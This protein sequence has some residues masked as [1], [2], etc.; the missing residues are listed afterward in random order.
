[1]GHVFCFRV[2][3]GLGFRLYSTAQVWIEGRARDMVLCR[4]CVCVLVRT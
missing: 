2:G 1:M 3:N 4:A